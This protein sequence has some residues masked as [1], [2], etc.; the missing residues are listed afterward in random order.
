M[1][2]SINDQ[3]A[4]IYDTRFSKYGPA[5]EASMWFSK[6]RQLTRFEV[7]LQQIL[8]VASENSVSISDIGCGYGAF[9]E[10]LLN[11]ED[12]HKYN[13]FGYDVSCNV[14]EFCK[15]NFLN[16]GV[17]YRSAS[18]KFATDFIIMSG[19]FN[20][21]PNTCINEWENYFQNSLQHLWPKTRSA[22]IF[23][24]QISDESRIT[25]SGIVYA[26]KR[27]VFNF[28]EKN[29]GQTTLVRNAKIPS[30][31]TFTVTK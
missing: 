23:N 9:L 25:S 19:T 8:Q 15:K 12:Y 7:I 26:N 24:L 4:E 6:T 30:D 28:C 17:F 27:D 1:L 20:F 5:P 10:Y 29:F 11:N 31:L 2:R 13:Y 16:N 14:I 3:I 22:M 18:P 21:F